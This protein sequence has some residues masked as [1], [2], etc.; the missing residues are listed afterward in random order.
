MVHE[1]RSAVREGGRDQFGFKDGIA[2]PVIEAPWAPSQQRRQPERG[3]GWRMLR[4]G[5]FVLGYTD[6]DG[7]LP[8][9]P[10]PP[11]DRNSTFVVYRKMHMHV[12]RFRAYLE[13]AADGI[14][15]GPAT[16]PPSSSAAG[17]TAR[18]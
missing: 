17:R 10:A 16:W 12:A 5:E 14:P 2:Q 3:G 11:F 6:E 7:G 1:Q 18:R 9:A 8:A 15:G 13:A 4:P